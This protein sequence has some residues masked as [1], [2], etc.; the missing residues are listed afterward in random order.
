MPAPELLIGNWEKGL[1]EKS[2][3]VFYIHFYG[4]AWTI[5]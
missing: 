1:Q 4:K 3:T 5:L 2:A